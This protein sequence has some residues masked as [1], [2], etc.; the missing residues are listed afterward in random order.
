MKTRPNKTTQAE[1][2]A[3]NASRLGFAN[4]VQ[5]QL[6]SKPIFAP[7]LP[8]TEVTQERNVTQAKAMKFR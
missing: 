6:K 7:D 5:V 1:G 8:R 3:D 4:P 2:G